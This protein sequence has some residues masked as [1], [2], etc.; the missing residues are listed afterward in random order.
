[1]IFDPQ[2]KKVLQVAT[3]VIR[4]HRIC[5]ASI[6]PPGKYHDHKAGSSPHKGTHPP[7]FGQ[8]FTAPA[9]TY[10]HRAISVGLARFS[11]P[12]IPVIHLS[13][14]SPGNLP[15]SD[16]TFEAFVCLKNA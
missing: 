10:D 2:I 13:R 6:G 12:A 16:K 5:T 4:P 9:N 15:D 11:R 1:M 14:F 3:K 8:P 7:V